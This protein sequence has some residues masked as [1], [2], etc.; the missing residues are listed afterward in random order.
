MGLFS[1]LKTNGNGS[2]EWLIVGL[3]NPGA[4]Y[5]RTRHNCGWLTIDNL[6]AK[7]RISVTR[8]KFKSM[9]GTA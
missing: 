2:I 9:C 4:K 6:A 1:K 7:Y 8:A 5:L 3:G